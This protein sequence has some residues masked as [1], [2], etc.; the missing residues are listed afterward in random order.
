MVGRWSGVMWWSKGGWLK[1]RRREG[2]RKEWRLHEV[3]DVRIRVKGGDLV[4]GRQ[5]VFEEAGSQG[6]AGPPGFPG[7]SQVSLSLASLP[8]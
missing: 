1:G 4:A 7:P 2:A 6:R 3:E 5:D 8:S